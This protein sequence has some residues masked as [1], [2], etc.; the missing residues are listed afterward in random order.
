MQYF[1]RAIGW[2]K[3]NKLATLLLALATF[4]FLQGGFYS[5]L[6]VSTGEYVPTRSNYGKVTA[7][8]AGFGGGGVSDIAKS[9][10]PP[11]SKTPPTDDTAD[12]KVIQNSTLSLQVKDV[13]Q[14]R[15]QVLNFTRSLGGYMVDS[16]LSRPQA[17]A[18]ATLTLRVPEAQLEKALG[19]YRSLAVQVVLENLQGRDVTDEYV[20]N[21]ERLKILQR[22]KVRFKEIMDQA[23]EIEDILRVQKEVFNLQAQIDNLIGRQ[24]YLEQ[25]AKLAKVTIYLATDEL[26]L[27]YTPNEPWSPQ[28]VFRRA[29][30][31]LVDNLRNLG[32]LTIWLGV[33]TILW[34][35]VVGVVWYWHRWQ[36]RMNLS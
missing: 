10:L 25:N 18:S 6:G 26:A 24:R 17:A 7:P 3:E 33:Y 14:A 28:A 32:S 20:D 29:V 23:N 1:S 30:R 34:I 11:R 21:E 27:P 16:K 8:Q 5:Q 12:R 31:S 2:M 15:D 19:Y 35:P 4:Y 9:V 13:A 36:G 22:N